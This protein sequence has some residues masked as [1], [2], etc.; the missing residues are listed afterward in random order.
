M[1]MPLVLAGPIL[2]R[3]EPRSVSVWVALSARRVMGL[4]VWQGLQ[5]GS[6]TGLL[7]TRMPD[8]SPGFSS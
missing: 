6:T 7:T 1:N 3:V 2:R 8:G 5:T 4:R